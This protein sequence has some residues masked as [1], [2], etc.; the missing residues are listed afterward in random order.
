MHKLALTLPGFNTGTG[1]TTITSPSGFGTGA[2]ALTNLG[3]VISGILEIV[4]FIAAFL[5][6]F[7][8]LWGVFRY[9]TAE[10]QKESLLKARNHMRWALVGFVVIILAFVLAQYAFKIIPQ[11]QI[12]PTPLNGLIN[13][14]KQIISGQ[15]AGVAASSPPLNV[16]Y[17]PLD[18][19]YSSFVADCTGDC[20]KPVKLI[21]YVYHQTE[22]TLQTYTASCPNTSAVD[23]AACGPTSLAMVS[24]AFNGH[25]PQA[26]TA[27]HCTQVL[28]D[29]GTM[30]CRAGTSSTSFGDYAGLSQSK[31]T[32]DMIQTINQTTNDVGVVFTAIN[33][34]FVPGTLYTNHSGSG[35]FDSLK[36]WYNGTCYPLVVGTYYGGY[37]S[38]GNE[39]Y[40]ALAGISDNFVWLADP[41]SIGQVIWKIPTS[42]Y[43]SNYHRGIF[44]EGIP[45]YGDPGCNQGPP[46]G[47][48]PP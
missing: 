48:F 43:I 30:T 9:L 37:H 13:S 38:L 25:D 1:N 12:T 14:L 11:Q 28:V 36:Q 39:H 29:N 35:S 7:W 2:F 6:F 21:P 20:K 18:Q 10:G 4:L 19:F 3:T 24:E 26:Q 40:S 32:D 31:S 27:N 15:G 41:L 5:L 16:E 45:P 47:G 22:V 46:Q 42:Y 44:W 17:I 33:S 34:D 8:L 23:S